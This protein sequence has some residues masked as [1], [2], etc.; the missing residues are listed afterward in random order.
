MKPEFNNVENELV[1]T[2]TGR[3]LWVSRSVAVVS[4]VFSQGMS[5]VLVV[6]R[7]EKTPDE[8]GKWCLPCGYLDWNESAIDAARREVWE[9]TGVDLSKRF[10]PL[11]GE[12][13]WRINSSPESNRQNVCLYFIWKLMPAYEIPTTSNENCEEGEVADVRWMHLTDALNTKMA[14]NHEKTILTAIS[15]MITG[16]EGGRA[17]FTGSF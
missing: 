7:G 11:T 14:F 6:K 9:E 10:V 16:G 13:P 4:L 5:S 8:V 1:K 2:T 17:Y 3:D 12:Q 15:N